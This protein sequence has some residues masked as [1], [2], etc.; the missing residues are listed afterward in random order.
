MRTRV[1]SIDDGVV[2]LTLAIEEAAEK[3]SAGAGGIRDGA[4]PR[5]GARP[6]ELGLDEQHERTVTALRL[7]DERVAELQ[8]LRAG[9]E[10]QVTSLG[11]RIDALAV[12]MEPGTARP[13]F[14]KTSVGQGFRHYR[15]T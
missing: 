13:G 9:A 15:Q 5:R 1:E 11:A 3:A 8:S 6:G 10:R 4:R 14:P 7:A 12:G 2:R